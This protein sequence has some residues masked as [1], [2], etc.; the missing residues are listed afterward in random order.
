[1][2]IEISSEWSCVSLEF[3]LLIILRGKGIEKANN[4]RESR[5]NARSRIR[6]DDGEGVCRCLQ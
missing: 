5:A 6:S 1:M 4:N 2:E 3:G